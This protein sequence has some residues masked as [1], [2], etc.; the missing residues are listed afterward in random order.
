MKYIFCL[1]FLLVPVWS[2]ESKIKILVMKPSINPQI[3]H[4]AW[5][6]CSIC[7]MDEL[8]AILDAIKNRLEHKDFPDSLELILNAPFQFNV[9]KVFVPKYFKNKIEILWNQPVKYPYIY[10]RSKNYSHSSWMN[11]YKW[12]KHKSFKHEFS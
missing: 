8:K 10:F 9:Q 1:I 6:E 12:V 4:L 7:N 5:N 11:K 3:V 2:K